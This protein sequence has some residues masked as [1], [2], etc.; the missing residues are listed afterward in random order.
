LHLG[1]TKDGQQLP[2]TDARIAWLAQPDPA[3]T[4]YAT[5]TRTVQDLLWEDRCV[6]RI[7][8]KS[9][10][11]AVVAAERVHPDQ[12]DFVTDP[13]NPDKVATWI[14]D[15]QEVANPL[16][17]LVIFDGAGI[18]GLSRFGFELLTLYGQLQTAAGRY[19]E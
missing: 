5:F 10:Y 11:G 14:I 3:A 19:A 18:G 13:R 16:D 9:L 2:S 12:I 17:Q 15:G 1:A 7:L 6:W 8:N 4:R